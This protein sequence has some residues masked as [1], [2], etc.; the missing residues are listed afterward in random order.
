MLVDF[1]N[2]GKGDQVGDIPFTNT[3][4]FASKWG[5]L[6]GD[7]AKQPNTAG[8]LMFDVINEPDGYGIRCARVCVCARVRAC[9]RGARLRACSCAPGRRWRA[10]GP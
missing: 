9:V 7:L 2:S 5:Q 3:A 8:K 1:H 4:D 10:R 6:A